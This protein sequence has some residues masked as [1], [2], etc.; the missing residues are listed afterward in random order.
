MHYLTLRFNRPLTVAP[1]LYAVISRPFDL[2]SS[3]IKLSL[4]SD[5]SSSSVNPII[6]IGLFIP[7]RTRTKRHSLSQVSMFLKPSDSTINSISLSFLVF[8]TA[9]E[10]RR[11]FFQPLFLMPQASLYIF[12]YNVIDCLSVEKSL[13]VQAV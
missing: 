11:L 3:L 4:S 13:W 9:W 6:S 5:S 2:I 12:A 10:P 7:V 1:E 8:P